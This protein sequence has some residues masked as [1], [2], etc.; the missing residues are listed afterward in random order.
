MI[1][2]A[3]PIVGRTYDEIIEHT[4]MIVD[5][6]SE[7]ESKYDTTEIRTEILEFRADYYE[8]V[9]EKTEL[10]DLLSEIRS[11]MGDRKLLFTYRSEDEG[12]E[13]RHDRAGFMLEDIYKWVGTAHLAEMMD[14]EL[15]SGNYRVARCAAKSRDLGIETVVSYHNF[16]E[17]PHDDK[18][19]E[20]FHNMEI[21]GGD[22]LKVAVTPKNEFDVR[23]IME[24][25]EK[26]VNRDFI[27]EED[28]INKP[29]VILSMGE[30]GRPSRLMVGEKGSYFT[31]SY[32]GNT[33]APGQIELGELFEEL[34]EKNRS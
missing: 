32:V 28:N 13:L 27:N 33:S 14:V 23:R 8:N 1:R 2:V 12:G 4:H 16:E 9:C 21:L 26:I 15:M 10:L 5:R 11:I 20:M 31:F 25:T 34:D 6:I 19:M 24:L 18:I 17:T 30:L 7:V 22:I 3:V 29:V